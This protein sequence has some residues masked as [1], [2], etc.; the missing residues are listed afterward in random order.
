[1]TSYHEHLSSAF[2]GEYKVFN[3]SYDQNEA[4]RDFNLSKS[5]FKDWKPDK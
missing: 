3:Q 4:K 1:M 5:I 2:L